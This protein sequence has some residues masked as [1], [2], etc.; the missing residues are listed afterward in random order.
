MA[1]RLSG[2]TTIVAVDLRPNRLEL[3]REVGATHV[4]DASA[5]DPVEEIRRITGAGVDYSLEATGVPAAVR[6]GVDALAPIGVCGVVGA[7]A[8]GTEV[9]L[10]VTTVMTGGRVVRGIVE[11]ESVPK[12]FL[13]RLVELWR[14]GEF[15]VDRMMRFYDFDEIDRAAHDAETGQVI[16]PVLRMD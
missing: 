12:H 10:D 14:R 15:P 6:A 5:A 8:L 16:K 9:S 3:A 11:G 2:C 13:P 1:A 7:P 4:V